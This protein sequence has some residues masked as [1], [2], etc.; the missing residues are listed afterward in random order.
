MH[1][2]PPRLEGLLRSENARDRWLLVL[3][4][5]ALPCINLLAF[6]WGT[7]NAAIVEDQWHFIPMIRDYF[8]GQFHLY[9]L[10]TSHSPHRTPGYKL[11]FLANAVFFKLDMRL[12]AL[13]GIAALTAGVLLLMKRFRDSLPASTPSITGLL[14]LTAIGITGFNLNQWGNLVYSL[15]ALAGYIGILCFVWVWLTLDTQLRLGAGPWKIAGLGLALAFTLM[16]FTAGM[17]PALIVSV[18]LVPAGI[19][20][21]ERRAA[22]SQLALLGSLALCALICELIYWKTGGIK[23]TNTHSQSFMDVLLHD[24]V[25]VPEYLV[26]AFASSVMPAEALEKHLHGPGRMLD[27]LV[28]TGV[29]CLYAACA[30]TYLCQRMWK[31]SY[32]PAFLMAFSTFFI[33]ST[34]IVRLP[35]MGLATSE[36]PRYVL[37][38]QLG[39]IGCLWVL[40][41]RAAERG[42]AGRNAWQALFSPKGFFLGAALLYVFGLAAL[43]AYHPQA[44]ANKATAVQKVLTGDFAQTD[45]VCPDSKLC[46]A[47]RATLMQYQLNVFAGNPRP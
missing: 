42:A 36:T 41:Q 12:E 47:G 9:S 24:P 25:A 6:T 1:G 46:D 31:A 32:L 17:G 14:G 45:W 10:W 19:M 35:S 27:L 8:T 40:F 30:Y 20:L 22:K 23:L 13:L 7:A 28:G 39:F 2:L 3:L 44:V 15:V 37:Y 4:I 21:I 26:L 5:T 34:L 38:S 16:S 11:L 33:L 43:W 18:L 29:I